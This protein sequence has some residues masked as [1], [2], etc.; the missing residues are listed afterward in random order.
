[1]SLDAIGII[2][3]KMDE[4]IQFYGL[5]G[6]KFKELGGPDHLE[7]TNSRG[8]RIMLDSEE[9]ARKLNPQWK[10]A[11]GSGVVLCFKQTS[12]LEVNQVYQNI[13]DSGFETIKEPWDAFWG[14]RYCSVRDPNG[15]QIDL[16][17][18]LP[19]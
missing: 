2:S 15:N 18:D 16:F 12:V 4:T 5:L 17:A 10:K 1:M 9:L 6:I 13:M 19:Q 14:Q 8:V 3:S 11:L 7:S